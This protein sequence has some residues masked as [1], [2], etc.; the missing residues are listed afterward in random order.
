MTPDGAKYVGE[1]S[2]TVGGWTCQPWASQTPHAHP[3]DDIAYFADAGA[4]PSSASMD[5][6]SNYCRNPALDSA[7]DA[8]PWCYVNDSSV[9]KDYCNIPL[10]MSRSTVPSLI[11]RIF[12]NCSTNEI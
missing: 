4:S 6:V 11:L 9:V 2:V 7:R 5:S 1:A 3:Y 10:C 12:R 8:A